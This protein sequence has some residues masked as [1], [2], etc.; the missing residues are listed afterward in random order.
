M[1]VMY[2]WLPLEKRCCPVCEEPNGDSPMT[3]GRS[4][5][6]GWPEGFTNRSVHCHCGYTTDWFGQP[7]FRFWTVWSVQVTWPRD[8]R[9]Q[10]MKRRR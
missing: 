10:K 3:H 7:V 2:W 6:H 9:P 4:S 5:Y 1:A 8:E